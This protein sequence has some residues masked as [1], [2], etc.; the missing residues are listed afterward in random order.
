[1]DADPSLT[2]FGLDVDDDLALLPSSA[3]RTA[4]GGW[5]RAQ[6]GRGLREREKPRTPASGARALRRRPKNDVDSRRMRIVTTAA[7]IQGTSRKRPTR[8]QMFGSLGEDEAA[9]EGHAIAARARSTAEARRAARTVVFMAA[10][11]VDPR[12]G[13]APQ[14][15]ERIE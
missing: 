14:E 4:D 9:H 12:H 1:V 3:R 8:G 10:S 2:T 11:V 15:I 5:L 7:R 6:A 13:H